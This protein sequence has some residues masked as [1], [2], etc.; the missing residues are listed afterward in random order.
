MDNGNVVGDRP[1]KQ[2]QTYHYEKTNR[3]S[4]NPQELHPHILRID[5]EFGSELLHDRRPA[6]SRGLAEDRSDLPYS[7]SVG[8]DFRKKGG[9]RRE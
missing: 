8:S 7:R 3:R 9:N 1:P 4:S 6:A 2:T 5:G